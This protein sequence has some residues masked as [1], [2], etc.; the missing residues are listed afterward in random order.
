[1]KLV[2]YAAALTLAL[3]VAACGSLR[4]SQT[5]CAHDPE[6]R[7]KL[8]RAAD[9]SCEAFTRPEYV[10]KG[11]TTYDQ[12][13]ADG[14]TEA[15]VGACGWERPKPRPPELDQRPAAQPKAGPPRRAP[16]VSL[17]TRL[18]RWIVPSAAA[19]PAKPPPAAAVEPTVTT[20][21][22]VP[23]PPPAPPDPRDELIG[24]R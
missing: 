6:C 23:V 2:G 10:V 8:A 14:T 18:K 13:W 5:D 20:V 11:K 15:G 7:A 3:T 21:R 19:A 16:K 22:T 9:P 1:M 4:S 24:P 12:R 17:R